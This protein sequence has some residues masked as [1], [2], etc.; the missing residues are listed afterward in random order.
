MIAVVAEG[1][2][3]S[4]VPQSMQRMALPGAIFCPIEA[5][6]TIEQGLYWHA[7]NANPCLEP[8]IKCAM[9]SAEQLPEA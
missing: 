2:G 3:V 7:N 8:F 1:L 4:L 9:R 6:P 5:A